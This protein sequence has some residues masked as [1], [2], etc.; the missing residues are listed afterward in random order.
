MA[1]MRGTGLLMPW[2]DVEAEPRYLTVYEFG[3]AQVP[4]QSAWDQARSGNP[5]NL[6]MR[7][8]V[9]LDVGAPAIYRRIWPTPA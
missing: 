5:W 4:D 2:T 9:Q 8:H 6:R 1:K 7:P 3:N